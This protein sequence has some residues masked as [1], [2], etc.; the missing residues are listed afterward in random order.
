MEICSRRPRHAVTPK[1][2]AA[3][4]TREIDEP[5]RDRLLFGVL[6]QQSEGRTAVILQLRH[7]DNSSTHHPGINQRANEK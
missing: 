4:A 2:N 7:S 5:W 3:T 6:G 1:E